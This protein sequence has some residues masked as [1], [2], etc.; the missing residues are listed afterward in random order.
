LAT[1]DNVTSSLGIHFNG[2]FDESNLITVCFNDNSCGVQSSLTCMVQPGTYF[3]GVSSF[4]NKSKSEGYFSLDI[5]CSGLFF[6]F[7]CQ[8]LLCLCFLS[9]MNL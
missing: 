5:S 6:L 9:E 1:N 8:L 4:A 2:S 3:I 7:L